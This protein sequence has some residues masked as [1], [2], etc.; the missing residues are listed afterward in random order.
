MKKR[1]IGLLIRYETILG[2]LIGAIPSLLFQIIKPETE[3][4]FS[5]FLSVLTLLLIGMWFCFASRA[6]AISELE[7]TREK[8]EEANGKIEEAHI[9]IESLTGYQNIEFRIT[10]LN[11]DMQKI[12][13]NCNADTNLLSKGQCLV[14]YQKK[15][16]F[17]YLCGVAYITEY[18]AAD[19]IAQAN[20]I[21]LNISELPDEPRPSKEYI[22]ISPILDYDILDFFIKQR[23]EVNDE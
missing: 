11:W 15:D 19:K 8:L 23:M 17:E 10:H 6:H 2:V 7:E 14:I 1:S 12:R 5:W 22:R 18:D 20:V 21:P 3:M 4:P 13:F 16:D 9:E